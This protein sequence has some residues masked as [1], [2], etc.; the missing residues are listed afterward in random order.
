MRTTEYLALLLIAI[1][2]SF[3][4]FKGIEKMIVN[5]ASRTAEQIER[6]SE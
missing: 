5:S 3:L 6:V 4:V 2:F 1:I